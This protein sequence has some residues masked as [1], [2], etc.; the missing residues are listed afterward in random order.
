MPTNDERAVSKEQ[1]DRGWGSVTITVTLTPM[2]QAFYLLH[3]KDSRPPKT[4]QQVVQLGVDCYAD[5]MASQRRVDD[6]MYDQLG[7]PQEDRVY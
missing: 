7:V 4:L 5:A 1:P 6:A 2:L 3:A